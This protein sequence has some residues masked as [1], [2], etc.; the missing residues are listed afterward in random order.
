MRRKI[1]PTNSLEH[2]EKKKDEQNLGR[3]LDKAHS[4][5]FKTKREAT[6]TGVIGP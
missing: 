3:R 6:G 2:F 1:K 4:L 5:S